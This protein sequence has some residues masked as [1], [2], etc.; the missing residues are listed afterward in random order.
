M[1][2]WILILVTGLLL[3][4]V[5]VFAA[6]GDLIVNGKIGIGTTNPI[7]TLDARNNVTSPIR[8]GST[9][10]VDGQGFLGYNDI[11]ILVGAHTI[12]GG[13]IRM[14]AGGLDVMYI[15]NGGKVGIGVSPSYQLHLS[16]DL[17]AKASTSTWTVTSDAR[18]KTDIQP[19]T[20]GLKEILQINPVSYKYNGKGGMGHKK[21]LNYDP[22]TGNETEIDILDTELLSKTN[23]GVIAQDIQ[24]V[25]P[26]SVSSRKGKLNK[27][28]AVETDILDF[29][30]HSLTFILINAVKELK[31][32]IDSLE[33]QIADLKAKVQ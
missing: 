17:A 10:Y 6:D 20:K 22:A 23:V 28:D 4:G 1:K 18:L 25:V 30:A 7:T 11:D 26:E 3:I 19:Y 31:A 14:R 5:N 9:N 33:K 27:D 15:G 24:A 12:T 2:K 13:N 16:D 29:N 21:I 32:Q 8:W